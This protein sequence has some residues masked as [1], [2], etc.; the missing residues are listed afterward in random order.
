MKKIILLNLFAL[1]IFGCSKPKT[2][3]NTETVEDSSEPTQ[4]LNKASEQIISYGKFTKNSST[5]PIIDTYTKWE[6]SE[7]KLKIYLTPTKITDE[8]KS[9]LD[10]GDSDFFVF[11]NKQSPDNDKW[12]WYPYVVTEISFESNEI[13]EQT[14]KSFY[15]MAYGIEEPN[16]TDNLNSYPSEKEKFEYLH[17]NEGILSVKYFGQSFI[18]ESTF[19]WDIKI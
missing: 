16:Y 17:L 15:I 12:Q 1:I 2:T 7:G 10:A 4:F 18:M 11:S 13:S 3:A 9:R 14:I 8:E 6:E 19:H 5:M